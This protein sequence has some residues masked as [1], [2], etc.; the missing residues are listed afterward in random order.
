ALSS[1]H[2]PLGLF[3]VVLFLVLGHALPKRGVVQPGLPGRLVGCERRLLP[4]LFRA[5]SIL[6]REV[7]LYRGHAAPAAPLEI[8]RRIATRILSSSFSLS[9]MSG[10]GLPFS[11]A[12]S[13]REIAAS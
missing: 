13:T 2:T 1:K 8:L 6:S 3:A 10:S 11:R 4:G 9:R 7:A 12:S 5:G